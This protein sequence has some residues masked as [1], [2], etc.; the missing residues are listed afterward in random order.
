MSHEQY[1]L[2]KRQATLSGMTPAGAT[3]YANKLQR[4][5]S[6]HA[7]DSN[8]EG[9]LLQLSVVARGAGLQMENGRKS[10]DHDCTEQSI[11][12]LRA[13]LERSRVIAVLDAWAETEPRVRQHSVRMRANCYTCDCVRVGSDG[14]TWLISRDGATIN[15]ARAAAAKAIESGEL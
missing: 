14:I 12:T 5:P 11:A 4:H 9:A 13:A 10:F 1:E 7:S 6:R 15:A 8:S 3:E 2:D